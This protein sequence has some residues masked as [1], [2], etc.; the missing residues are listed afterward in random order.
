M[1][2]SKGSPPV[3]MP[4]LAGRTV[5]D[6]RRILDDAG[7]TVQ[8]RAGGVRPEVDGGR[9]IGTDPEAGTSKSARAAIDIAGVQRGQGAVDA[10]AVA[11]ARHGTNS[12]DLG[13]DVS[14]RQVADSDR[15]VVIAQSPGANG[16]AEEGSTVTLT[17]L[18]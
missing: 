5:D 1:C 13:F 4:D 18:P 17:A 12:P 3:D 15:S 7:L 2:V 14:V 11:S 6:A 16:R 8:R 9:V 10:R